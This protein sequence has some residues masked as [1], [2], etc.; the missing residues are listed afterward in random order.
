MNRLK[1]LAAKKNH[2]FL[3]LLIL[4]LC[5]LQSACSSSNNNSKEEAPTKPSNTN[6]PNTSPSDTS[7][8]KAAPTL[9]LTPYLS[10]SK[11]F[12]VEGVKFYKDIPYK[13]VDAKPKQK[14][15]FYMPESK[16]T[17]G[18]VIFYHG[19]AFIGGDKKQAYKNLRTDYKSRF[20][21]PFRELLGMGIAVASVNYR[22]IQKATNT[23]SAVSVKT[24]IKDM[25]YFLQFARYYANSLNINAE[26]IILSGESAG[27]SAALLIGLH[28]NEEDR[29]ANDPI[30]KQSTRV[31]GLA[32]WDVPASMN[33]QEIPNIFA[34]KGYGI[35]KK[36]ILISQQGYMP[37]FRTM[38]ALVFGAPKNI[39]DAKTG[40]P[41]IQKTV[42]WVRNDRSVK[43]LNER[44]SIE[45]GK[46]AM[47]A[48]DPELWIKN[49]QI[50]NKEPETTYMLYHHSVHAEKLHEWAN[51]VKLEHQSCWRT[52]KVS[53]PSAKDITKECYGS[54]DKKLSETDIKSMA[55]FVK[56]K[57]ED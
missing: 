26:K 7:Q 51:K 33:I 40:F 34:G 17:T 31:K 56:N 5:L 16:N 42:S 30:L 39:Y 12:S 21:S 10:E 9:N 41:N 2:N 13:K 38:L 32:L 53:E 52:D 6:Q 45:P 18:L 1:R 23:Q 15:D 19:G 48:D 25:R 20:H 27:A 47:T 35:N 22:F 28:D 44:L 57:F 50:R 54:G 29:N 14:F 11:P 36:S 37:E 8:S 46:G 3:I 24:P 49:E 43:K 4:S 55:E